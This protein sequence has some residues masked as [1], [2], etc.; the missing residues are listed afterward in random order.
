ME[1][2]LAQVEGA[3][4]GRSSG[5]IPDLRIR[6]WSIDS[7]TTGDGDLFFAIKGERRDGHAFASAALKQGAIA[8]VVSEPAE[9]A[10][11][12][13]LKVPDTQAALQQLARW[14]RNQWARPIVAVTGSAG[15]T[16][17]KDVIAELLGVRFRVG[18]TAGNLNNH[19]G[20]PLSIL[21]IPEDAEIGVIELGMN[22]AGE[23][24]ALAAISQPEIGVVTN[25]GFAHIETFASIEELAA[26][27]REL[28]E[29]L[30]ATGVALLNADDERVAAFSAVN[31]GRT[32]TYG[33]SE[34]ADVRATQVDMNAD[35]AAFTAGGVRFRTVLTGR[36]SVSNILAGLAV[37]SVFEIS[38]GELVPAVAGLAPGEMRGERS[39]WRGVTVLNDSYNSNP[40]A[41][42]SMIDVLR[43]EPAKR[44]IAVLGEMLEL[45][46][47]SE[48]LHRDIGR[49]AVSA[50]LDVLIGVR[51]V[52]QSMIEEAQ[53]AGLHPHAAFFFEE[54]ESAG[55]FLRK[56]VR[57]GDAI[58]F[59]G[60]RG[61]HIEKALARMEA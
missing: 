2:S 12:T 19:I 60:S 45:G 37:A 10:K 21:R 54:P 9:D 4:R 14:A 8:A 6:G 56:F 11:G 24:R 36:H 22:H 26:A 42:R 57:P 30:P 52:S 20:L 7:R 44:R 53:K 51:G 18:K 25:V 41:A 55:E 34:H 47:M 27:K 61:T 46:G 15:K 59:K 16:T 28:I 3:I 39:Q 43:A 38:F 40:E 17:T 13:L 23:I 1:F 35:G 50:G 48:A 5:A 49:Y 32:L 31:A 58:L 29:A 33:F